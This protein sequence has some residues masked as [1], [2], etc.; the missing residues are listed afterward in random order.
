MRIREEKT[1]RNGFGTKDV[2][3]AIRELEDEHENGEMETHA[4]L[5]KK[6]SLVK[7]L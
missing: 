4:Y 6:R 3:A 7:M 5:I 2:L 1:I